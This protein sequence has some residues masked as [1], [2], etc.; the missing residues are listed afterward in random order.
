M[1]KRKPLS[2]TVARTRVSS[3][4][5]FR[6]EEGQAGEKE[7]EGRT[8]NVWRAA[9]ADERVN[10][11]A[12]DLVVV[13]SGVVDGDGRGRADGRAAGGGE[14][15]AKDERACD[16]DSNNDGDGPLDACGQAQ[17]RH[18]GWR[19]V[20]LDVLVRSWLETRLGRAAVFLVGRASLPSYP[21]PSPSL[22]CPSFYPT[23]LQMAVRPLHTRVVFWLLSACLGLVLWTY[24]STPARPSAS[25]SSSVATVLA[26]D[27]RTPISYDL[28]SPPT[29]DPCYDIIYDGQRRLVEAYRY[30]PR[31]LRLPSV[32]LSLTGPPWLSLFFLHVFSPSL[33]SHLPLTLVLFQGAAQGHHPRL[34]PRSSRH[35][36]QG[37]VHRLVFP[38]LA[39]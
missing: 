39:V 14:G 15:R 23:R 24:L 8:V 2:R 21:T 37:C 30:S 9:R 25:S 3:E 32:S 16:E 18:G 35:G 11:G 36:E 29:A 26:H 27:G 7:G 33:P 38:R 34:H 1:P 6:T 12:G 13:A 19:S 31:S 20:M 17:G 10:E 4:R 28:T 5:D 22:S